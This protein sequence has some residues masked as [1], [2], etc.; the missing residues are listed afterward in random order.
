MSDH[1][2]KWINIYKQSHGIIIQTDKQTTHNKHSVNHVY[3]EWMNC[4]DD[5]D[6]C[7]YQYYFIKLFLFSSS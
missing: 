6:G 5:E 4:F 7:C 2:Y 1:K 3:L